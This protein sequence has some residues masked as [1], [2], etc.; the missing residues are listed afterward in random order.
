[1]SDDLIRFAKALGIAPTIKEDLPFPEQDAF[2]DDPSRFLAALCTR[3]AGKTNAV[4][5][6]FFRTLQ[7]HPGCFCPYI[8]LTRESARNIMWDIL[9][10]HSEKLKIKAHF[11]ESNL[12]MT[13]ENGSRLQLFGADMK[14]FI[15]RLK[16][17]KTPGAAV[18]EAQDFGPHIVDL[19]DGVLT[20]TIADYSDGW[21]AITG[22]PGPVPLGLFYE[23]TEQRKYGYAVHQWS[24]LNNPYLPNAQAFLT[25][26]RKKKQWEESNP[27]FQREWLGKWVMDLEALVYKYEQDKND[28]E[29]LPDVHSEWDYIIGV[30]I[31]H[32]DADAIAVIAWNPRLKA[33][34]LVEE[35]VKAGQAITEL[36]EQI[37]ERIKKYSPLK[38][39]M[40][41]GGLGKKIAEEMRRRYAL[42][43]IAAEK[44][45]KFEFIALLND[46]MRMRKFYAKKDSHFAKDAARVK[47]DR[48]SAKLKV[49]DHFHSDI[50]DAVLY[51][52]R[53]SLHW[54]YE[55]EVHR[56]KVN[57][58]EWF[59]EQEKLMEESILNQLRSEREVDELFTQGGVSEDLF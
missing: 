39:V 3:R 2:V 14:N 19:V 51:A 42:P 40:D 15:R 31:G 35:F 18:D 56:P 8:A 21:L 1:M 28:Y 23:V 13:L 11:T 10:E 43:I 34:Y 6:R 20:P 41:T 4:A 12:T 9:H 5:R 26:L 33:S 57:T 46:A 45:R 58:Q 55:P 48:E 17:I 27:T 30:D 38:V 22:T 37:E 32:D 49:S 25:E 29:M 59:E 44:D 54:L 50:C 47:W 16:G 24:I 52:F 7:S 53:E 36:A